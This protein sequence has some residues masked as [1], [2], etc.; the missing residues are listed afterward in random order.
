M[1]RVVFEKAAP[2]KRLEYVVQE[3]RLLYHLLLAMLR[4][5]DALASRPTP[6]VTHDLV[7]WWRHNGSQSVSAD[8]QRRS[9]AGPRLVGLPNQLHSLPM[10]AARLPPG[11]YERLL[12]WTSRTALDTRRLR[13]CRS[14]EALH[15]QRRAGGGHS[16]PIGNKRT[17]CPRRSPRRLSPAPRCFR[18]G[19][20]RAA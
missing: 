6:D 7:G 4:D 10:P 1:L 20:D 15:R 13:P 12:A 11:L 8:G 9:D 18:R 3:D 19:R 2:A 5:K 16:P 14:R 17:R